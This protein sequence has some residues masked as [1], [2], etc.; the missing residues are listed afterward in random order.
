MMTV[1]LP[2]L[3]SLRVSGNFRADNDPSIY[4]QT[5]NLCERPS[6]LTY[7]SIIIIIIFFFFVFMTPYQHHRLFLLCTLSTPYQ[8]HRLFLLCL[9]QHHINIIIA[10]NTTTNIVLQFS[11]LQ[12]LRRNN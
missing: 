7:L 12:Q 10:T 1:G 9:Y 5:R 8:H 2:V 11:T 3:L 4:P 6:S